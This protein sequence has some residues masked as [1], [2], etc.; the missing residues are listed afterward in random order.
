[1]T[2]TTMAR[3]HAPRRSLPPISV[4]VLVRRRRA[5]VR[6]HG[7]R[8]PGP[9]GRPASDGREPQ[10]DPGQRRR[11]RQR[12][13]QPPDPRH[14]ARGATVSTLDVLDQGDDWIFGFSSGGIDGGS[15]RV[16]R[17]KLA[18]DG[19][20]LVV[21]EAVVARLQ[22]VAVRPGV[23]LSSVGE[24]RDTLVALGASLLAAGLLARLG[25]SIG[26]P[27]D[28]AVHDRRAAVRAE[29]ARDPAR[30]RPGRLR[31][32]RDPRPDP[33]ALLPRPRVLPRRAHVGRPPPGRRRD[34][35][36][37]GST[38]APAS[39]SASRSAGARREALVIAGAV[40]IS[41]SAIVT[42]ILVEMRRLT[43]R[44]TAADPRHRRRRRPLPRRV[45][46]RAAA[47]ARRVGRARST[48]CSRSRR[49]SGSSSS[50]R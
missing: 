19:W 26:L 31:A 41:S 40:G 39:R 44:E 12:R 48:R 46:R 21:P 18:A 7:D 20:R 33:A 1:M 10:H 2:Q 42:K 34:R 35:S 47:G 50:S 43:N 30:R 36:T 24:P 37:S 5:V 45:P 29:H 22:S 3:P 32:A 4:V 16:S 14:R 17:A 13:R 28:P 11:A 15:V 27:D 9:R 38:S 6:R 49:R 23:P 25:R 8:A